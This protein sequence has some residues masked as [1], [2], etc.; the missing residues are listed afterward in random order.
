MKQDQSLSR[1]FLLLG[2]FLVSIWNIQAMAALPACS[3]TVNFGRMQ[4]DPASTNMVYC[5][6]QA[7]QVLGGAMGDGTGCHWEGWGSKGQGGNGLGNLYTNM[8]TGGGT[9]A[10]PASGA[11]CKIG[12]YVAAVSGT[13]VSTGAKRDFG[14]ILCCPVSG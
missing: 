13:G 2:I 11:F 12:E 3:A 4:F 5:N 1:I 10:S 14:V 7:W 6:V 8:A 9:P